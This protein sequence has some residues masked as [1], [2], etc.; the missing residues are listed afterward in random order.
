LG[1]NPLL[2]SQAT[3][4]P[5][6]EVAIKADEISG[7]FERPQSVDQLL[8][9]LSTPVYATDFE[10]FAPG[11][12]GFQDGW[13][14]VPSWGIT[15]V[16]PFGGVQHLRGVA[17]GVGGQ[18]IAFSPSVG[19]GSDSIS[20]FSAQ[21][22]VELGATWQI[23][24]QSPTSGFVVTIIQ[25]DPTGV[26]SVAA[27]IDDVFQ[28]V[29][30][31]ELAETYVELGLEV[32]RATGNFV[33]YV[34]GFPAFEGLGSAGNIEE[35]VFVS[36]DEASS[37]LNVD[38]FQIVDGTL[39]ARPI[40]ALP[41]EGTLASGESL[42][43]FVQIDATE[44]PPGVYE[45]TLT[46]R[47]SDPVNPLVDVDITV[48]V[49]GPPVI[50]VDPD[51]ISV[52]LPQF[53]EGASTLSIANLGEA[54]LDYNI[55]IQGPMM[56]IPDTSS[57]LVNYALD[58]R[59]LQ[60]L[61][62]KLPA[63]PPTTMA[64][65]VI[66]GGVVVLFEEGFDGGEFPPAGWDAIDNAGSGLVWG[67]SSEQRGPNFTGGNGDAASADSDWFGPAPYDTELVT[68]PIAVDGTSGLVLEYLANFRPLE[69]DMF[70][71]DISVDGGV[72]WTNMISWDEPRGGFLEGPGGQVSIPLDTYL[73]GAEAFQV[74]WRYYSPN[75]NDP[76]DWYAQID[77]VRVGVSWV[78]VD[79]VAGTV[80]GGQEAPVD[81]LF[82]TSQLPVGTF[83]VD[84]LINSN[85]VEQPSLTV[86][87][88]LEVLEDDRQ[89]I[90]SFTLINSRTDKDIREIVDGDVI[91]LFAEGA[92]RINIR[93]NVLPDEVGSVKLE[94][95]GRTRRNQTENFAPYALFGDSPRGN[96]R[97]WKPKLGSYTLT[98]TPFT[99]SK[100]RGEAGVPLTISF[101][102]VEENNATIDFSLVD[103]VADVVVG[104][105]ADGAVIDLAELELTGGIS[106]QANT[107]PEMVGSM[108][109]V[110]TGDDNH[111][112]TENFLP[113]A[114]FGD[115]PRGDF[116]VW[117]PGPGS[118]SLTARAYTKR[119]R[120]GSVSADFTLDF[121]VV[122][123]E[124]TASSVVRLVSD[125][126]HKPTVVP[127]PVN[128]HFELRFP[129]ALTGKVEVTIMNGAG[130]VLY[131]R[132][133]SLK[134]VQ[135][136]RFNLD[137]GLRP[138]VYFLRVES[139][140]DLSM[141]QLIKQ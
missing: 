112:Q 103:A 130:T 74:R 33:L 115:N 68:P 59:I 90:Q 116:N 126:N 133:A 69:G 62:G 12:L 31:F 28:F 5:K 41:R 101:E 77:N 58:S 139:P 47:N 48:N 94:L 50:D 97:N 23:A 78:S 32:D 99:Q 37:A 82:N 127:N 17:T 134:E 61:K 4:E 72:T 25:I 120:K 51:S 40:V 113:Y 136:A 87:V 123:S 35:V 88:E 117:K 39:P 119:N 89:R 24:P 45:E 131:Q 66:S 118:Y 71:A 107:D 52:S 83:N 6:N 110:L 138:G 13:L 93:A 7:L 79:P 91:N 102:I 67:L 114:L 20:S 135:N 92:D 141:F 29:P 80:E 122:E 9:A 76:W 38:N 18:V 86:P 106:I 140:K 111:R 105:L 125:E 10:A 108:E 57:A 42:E 75:P 2:T 109:L 121:T 3:L 19:I 64:S 100:G 132:A 14:S 70:D 73:G 124:D 98:A 53:T 84:L 137:R 46:I 60:K 8:Q 44:L 36:G 95:R 81:V 128:N 11:P 55:Q 129:K 85:D 21:F 1:S 63:P 96:Y 26:L 15:G 27:T 104:P 65:S 54:G 56:D 22:E 49:F 34:D 16:A 43:V 30:L